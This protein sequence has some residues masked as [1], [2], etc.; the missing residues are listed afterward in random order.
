MPA[1]KGFADFIFIPKP[2]YAIDYPA[3]LA[4]LNNYRYHQSK[5]SHY[6]VFYIPLVLHRLLGEWSFFRS[7]DRSFQLFWGTSNGNYH[8]HIAFQSGLAFVFTSVARSGAFFNLSG[9]RPAR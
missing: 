1:G 8:R 2:E 7:Q 6:A 9:G 4:E 5:D 3:L